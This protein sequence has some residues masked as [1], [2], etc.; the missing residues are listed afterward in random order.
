[1]TNIKKS[2]AYPLKKFVNNSQRETYYRGKF[3]KKKNNKYVVIFD[4]QDSSL[5][6]NLSL[7]NCLVK[8]PAKKTYYKSDSLEILEL[9]NCI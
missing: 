7:A 2:K 5:M 3:Y 6:K 4:S 1:M 9:K 8:I